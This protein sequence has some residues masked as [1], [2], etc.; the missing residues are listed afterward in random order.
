M[1]DYSQEQFSPERLG[2]GLKRTNK[3]AVHESACPATK[4]AAHELVCKAKKDAEVSYDWVQF[5]DKER[6]V[7]PFRSKIQLGGYMTSTGLQQVLKKAHKDALF[8]KVVDQVRKSDRK[9]VELRQD[10]ALLRD[11]FPGDRLKLVEDYC[12][13]LLPKLEHNLKNEAPV[14]KTTT[15]KATLT[16]RSRRAVILA[17]CRSQGKKDGRALTPELLEEINNRFGYQRPVKLFEV[18]RWQSKLEHWGLLKR[19]PTTDPKTLKPFFLKALGLLNQL[20]E[21]PALATSAQARTILALTRQHLLTFSQ[22][23]KKAAL[24]KVCLHKDLDYAARL[25]IWSLAKFFAQTYC[26]LTFRRPDTLEG[27]R[28]LFLA[29]DRWDKP[30]EAVPVRTWKYIFWSEFSLRKELLALGLFPAPPDEKKR[31]KAE[32]AEATATASAAATDTS[33]G[34]PPGARK[35]TGNKRS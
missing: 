24:L 35:N 25:I 20:Q 14:A 10:F 11:F 18:C 26:S 31:N 34:N 22:K 5:N 33:P 1:K 28:T 32:A 23:A 19:T 12:E 9:Q 15:S 30:G 2:V 6:P 16:P 21:H 17:L 13:Q 3:A 4:G 8:Y 7:R 27:W 29:Y